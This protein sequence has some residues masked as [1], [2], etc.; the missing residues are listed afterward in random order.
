MHIYIRTYIHTYMG[1]H[2]HIHTYIH[3][4]ILTCGSHAHETPMCSFTSVLVIFIANKLHT[5]KVYL[6][7][8]IHAL[9]YFRINLDKHYS[10]VDSSEITKR[11]WVG[12]SA[13]MYIFTGYRRIRLVLCWSSYMK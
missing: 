12:G 9:I 8:K 3:T 11:G 5:M 6:V 10:K 13:V 7:D 1:L 2:A 4:Y